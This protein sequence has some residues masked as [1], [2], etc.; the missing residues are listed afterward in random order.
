MPEEIR[1]S[2]VVPAF[3]AEKSIIASV[4][5]CLNQTTPPFEVIVVDDGSSDNTV[6]LLQNHFG[7]RINL[8]QQQKNQGPSSARNRGEEAASGSHIAFQDADDFWHPR[9]LELVTHALKENPGISFLF[10]RY[11]LEMFSD[12][13][14]SKEQARWFSFGKLLLRNVVAMPCA[15]IRRDIMQP[16]NER[17]KY[18]EDYELFLRLAYKHELYLLDLPL[19]RLGRPVLSAGGQSEQKLKMRMGEV[20]AWWSL[21][22][23]APQYFLAMP[24]LVV[25]SAMKH[26]GKAAARILKSD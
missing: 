13:I 14:E 15:I 3:N 25:L 12:E 11:T 18:M 9:K 24:F 7:N 19:T 16:F 22:K 1:I 21:C 4:E 2:V 5:S 23:Q 20:K 17:M 26:L 8:I 10:H 6:T